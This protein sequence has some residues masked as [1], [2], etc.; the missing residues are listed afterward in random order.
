MVK[1]TKGILLSSLA[2]LLLLS[3]NKST[4]YSKYESIDVDKGWAKGQQI[5]FEVDIKDTVSR[6][7]VFINVRNADSYPFR[8]LFLFLHTTY[9]DGNVK[10]D[11][12]E[13]LL[14][15]EKGQWLGK[16]AG[17]LWDNT[18]P[19]KRNVRFPMAGKYVFSFEQAMR[20][21]DKTAID[22]LPLILDI[23]L[24]IEKAEEE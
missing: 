4:V 24:T 15:D 3:C 10:T 8:N 11:T 18:I 19:F 1:R 22:P 6:N 5:K 20:S 12:L 21:G 17:D 2:L 13:C 23:G 7:N 9:P 16:G 14:S